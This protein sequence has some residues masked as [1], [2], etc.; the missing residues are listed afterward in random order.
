MSVV[1]SLVSHWLA[2]Q[3]WIC[4]ECCHWHFSKSDLLCG[5]LKQRKWWFTF[6]MYSNS[7]LCVSYK[8]PLIIYLFIWHHIHKTDCYATY[9]SAYFRWSTVKW[10]LSACFLSSSKTRRQSDHHVSH[11]AWCTKIESVEL[12][13]SKRLQ[14]VASTDTLYN[15]TIFKELS[16]HF[17]VKSKSFKS[18]LTI[19]KT[20]RD[21]TGTYY[22]GVLTLNKCDFAFTKTL[23]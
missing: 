10:H 9:S 2:L 4:Y 8:S 5:S 22:C 13:T 21:D 12:T 16:Q 19:S 11:S 14:L 3:G 20:I 7:G 18:H 1:S 17:L 23:N 15:L 6:L